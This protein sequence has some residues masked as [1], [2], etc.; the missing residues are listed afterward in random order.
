MDFEGY[1]PLPV[2]GNS[3]QSFKGLNVTH[4]PLVF[5]TKIFFCGETIII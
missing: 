1:L 4:F 3:I 5:L 2:W